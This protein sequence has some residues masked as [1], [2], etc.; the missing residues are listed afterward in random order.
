MDLLLWS[1][2][3]GVLYAFVRLLACSSDWENFIKVF[4]VSLIWVT[5]PSSIPIIYVWSFHHVLDFL[6]IL[7]LEVYRH[8]I[9]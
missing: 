5:S 6:D 4:Y 9:F 8:N 3:F 7:I 1:C 2:V